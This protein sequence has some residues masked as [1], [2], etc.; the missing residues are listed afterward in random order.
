MRSAASVSIGRVL[1]RCTQS[2]LL[3]VADEPVEDRERDD[4]EQEAAHRAEHEAQRA[5]ERAD[6]GIENRV[7]QP[8]G[9]QRHHDQRGEEDT[10]AAATASSITGLWM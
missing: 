5:V 7:G 2:G 3:L 4:R 6:L 1:A 8:D 9:E 10:I